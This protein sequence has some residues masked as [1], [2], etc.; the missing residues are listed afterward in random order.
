VVLCLGDVVV[1]EL[2]DVSGPG[3][4]AALVHEIYTKEC[5]AGMEVSLTD[6]D[7]KRAAVRVSSMTKL[8]ANKAK[9]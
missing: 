5:N 7:V 8:T 6:S 4:V 1:V 9:G 3:I 2:L